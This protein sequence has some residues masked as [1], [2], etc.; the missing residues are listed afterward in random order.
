MTL[1]RAE[2]AARLAEADW[3]NP[4]AEPLPLGEWGRTLVAYADDLIAALALTPP[5]A[6]K[7]E[8]AKFKDGSGYPSEG[9][10]VVVHRLGTTEGFLIHAKHLSC[11]KVGSVGTATS[12][13]PGHGGD[14]WFVRHDGDGEVAAY[15]YDELRP[16]EPSPEATRPTHIRVVRRGKNAPPFVTDGA[17]LK[18][19]EWD[20]A[21][22]P[23]VG[24]GRWCFC[25]HR[26]PALSNTTWE[27]AT[28]PAP[29]EPAKGEAVSKMDDWRKDEIDA[30]AAFLEFGPAEEPHM[31]NFIAGWCH[32]LRRARTVRS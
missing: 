14:V 16:V 13:V 22:D 18:V 1:D 21:G 10:R 29:V 26:D 4:R 12:Y 24:D 9:E 5:V 6:P 27:P 23:W 17:V 15:M 30:R 19:D 11:R 25:G 32:A 28:P 7:S 31:A 3:R 2:V 8:A 20:A